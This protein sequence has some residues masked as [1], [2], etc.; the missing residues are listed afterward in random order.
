MLAHDRKVETINAYFWQKIR[1]IIKKLLTKSK[2]YDMIGFVGA[3]KKSYPTVCVRSSA[4]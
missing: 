3:V 4:G 2:I 1:K